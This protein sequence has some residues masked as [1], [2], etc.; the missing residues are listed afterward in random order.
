[1]D[2]T[3]AVQFGIKP[4]GNDSCKFEDLLETSPVWISE[5]KRGDGKGTK[6]TAV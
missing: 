5:V 3:V 1:M 4:K 6:C 2:C